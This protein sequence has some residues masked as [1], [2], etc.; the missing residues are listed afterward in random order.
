MESILEN[1]SKIEIVD[2][3]PKKPLTNQKAF[4][5][6]IEKDPKINELANK[7]KE[8]LEKEGFIGVDDPAYC[9]LVNAILNYSFIK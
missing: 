1:P 9:E 4:L 8:K 6:K 7:L 2:Y 3:D 5:E